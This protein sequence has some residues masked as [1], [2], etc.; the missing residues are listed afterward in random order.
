MF[1]RVLALDGPD[2][3]AGRANSNAF[4]DAFVFVPGL[5]EGFSDAEEPCLI[6]N[7]AVAVLTLAADGLVATACVVVLDGLVLLERDGLAAVAAAVGLGL[8]LDLGLGFEAAPVLERVDVVEGPVGFFAGFDGDVLA[9]ETGGG[10]AGVTV[11]VRT[12]SAVIMAV[13]AVSPLIN[14]EFR[15]ESID[16][17]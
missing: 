16:S 13:P 1:G 17:P 10:L 8:G 9:L 3:G 15:E 12:I 4:D 2:H 5:L 6:A 7:A 11:D 14:T